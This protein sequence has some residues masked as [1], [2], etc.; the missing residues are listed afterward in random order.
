MPDEL[1]E[2]LRRFHDDAFPQYRSHFRLL[3]DD[4]QRP[5]TLF[6][7]GRDSRQ[8]PYL[9]TGAGLGVRPRQHRPV[10]ARRPARRPRRARRACGL[11]RPQ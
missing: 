9:L 5:M 6:I 2:R 11:R 8:V 7:G 10:P 4:G 3:V 1:I